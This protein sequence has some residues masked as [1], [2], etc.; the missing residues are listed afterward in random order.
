MRETTRRRTLPAVL[1]TGLAAALA[2]VPLGCENKPAPPPKA[3]TADAQGADAPDA[4]PVDATP[5]SVTGAGVAPPPLDGWETPALAI[6]LSG[7]QHGYVEPCGC[8]EKQSGGLARRDDLVKILADR[9]WPVVGLDTGGTLK[10]AR[11]QSKLKFDFTHKALADMDYKALGLGP[12][13]LRL[14][15]DHLF[16]AHSNAAADGRADVPFVSANVVFYGDR[17]VGAPQTHR[18]FEAGGVKVGVTGVLGDEYAAAFTN[19][20]VLDIEPAAEALAAVVPKLEAEAPDV[21]V[22]LAHA[23]PSESKALAEAFPQFDVVV[24]ADG[25]EDG[26]DPE[27]VGQTL[28]LRPSQKGKHVEVLAVYKTDAG[29]QLKREQVDLDKDRFETSARMVDHMREYQEAIASMDLASTEP[30]YPA[31][32]GSQFAGAKTCGKCHT[33]AYGIWKNSKHAHALESL[34]V[35]RPGTESWWVDRRQDPECLSCHVTGWDPQDVV[36]FEGGFTSLAETKHLAGNQC[37]NC[38]G[39]GQTHSQLEMDFE[40]GGDLTDAHVAAR[41]D[42][43][44]EKAWA[45][46]NLCVKCH[47]GD[48][49]P[50]FDFATYW[51]KV[52]HK[53]RN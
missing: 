13:E 20:G 8:S 38:H 26:N 25:P 12:E 33:K 3:R 49:S 9:G 5:V 28:L 53:G 40:R 24:T 30:A 19:D 41:K 21:T 16:V 46:K 22:L 17:G 50:G 6:L 44:L 48:N 29:V 10:R 18:V 37:E 47:D 27:M 4:D 31:P 52:E 23:K 43:R 32:N 45:E 51:P 35:G 34:E 15:T 36:R 42:M 39:A 7:E 11:Q 2:A 1:F 14:G